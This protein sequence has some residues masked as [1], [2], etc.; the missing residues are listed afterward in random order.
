MGKEQTQ[1]SN[2]R[3]NFNLQ[4]RPE[5]FCRL[6]SETIMVCLNLTV[7]HTPHP[8]RQAHKL[9]DATRRSP[10]GQGDSATYQVFF[11]KEMAWYLQWPQEHLCRKPGWALSLIGATEKKSSHGSICNFLSMLVALGVEKNSIEPYQRFWHKGL[12]VKENYFTI[13]VVYRTHVWEVSRLVSDLS[14]PLFRS[15][16]FLIKIE[17]YQ[18]VQ[19]K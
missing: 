3:T 9:G 17:S 5:S 6:S 4:V 19:R 12:S 16:Q 10:A 14:K 15:W 11:L 7:C 13:T 2:S 1:D 18:R 8:S